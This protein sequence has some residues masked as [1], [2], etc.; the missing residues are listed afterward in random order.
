VVERGGEPRLADE[1]LPEPL[2]LGQL[3]REDLERDLPLEPVVLGEVDDAHPPATEG[4]HDPVTGDLGARLQI[5]PARANRGRAS[6]FW[7][8]R[9]EVR[10]SREDLFVQALQLG[11]G[12]GPELVA[13]NLASALVGR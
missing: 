11:R 6:P 4:A 10:G 8:G 12:I 1:S 3:R 7:L 9:C 2:V 5:H 13:E